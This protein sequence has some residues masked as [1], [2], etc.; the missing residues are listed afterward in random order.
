MRRG[1]AF[2]SVIMIVAVVV[3][4]AVVFSSLTSTPGTTPAPAIESTFSPVPTTTPTPKPTPKPT[5]KPTVMPVKT[6]TPTPVAT[7]VSGGCS[8]FDPTAGLATIT[9]TL[10]EKDSKPLVGDWIVKI[11]PTGSCQG[12]LPPNW[13]SQLNEVIKQPNYT[14]TS[15][16]MHPG[17]FRVDVQYHYTG[18]GFDWD[19]TSGGHSRE[20]QVSN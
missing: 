12:I 7:V 13:G 14:Y 18:E 3:I 2:L 4:T 17:Q 19:G 16:G 1:I 8:K 5:L 11:K 15:P 10:K 9:I 6:I 20:I